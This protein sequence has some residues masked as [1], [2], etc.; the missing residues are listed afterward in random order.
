MIV[1]GGDGVAAFDHLES[2]R[3]TPILTT[4]SFDGFYKSR[5]AVVFL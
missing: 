5:R 1:C 2:A 3:A 4:D